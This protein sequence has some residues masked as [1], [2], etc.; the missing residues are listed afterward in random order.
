VGRI[1]RLTGDFGITG[2]KAIKPD[3]SIDFHLP[4]EEGGDCYVEVDLDAG[5]IDWYARKFETETGRSFSPEPNVFV[6]WTLTGE[7]NEDLVYE[8]AG[9]VAPGTVVTAWDD[10]SGFDVEWG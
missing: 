3:T 8:V 5:L 4:F 1:E 6:S 2:L 9:V 10:V 7:V